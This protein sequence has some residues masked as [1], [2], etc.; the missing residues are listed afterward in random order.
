MLYLI[1][2]LLDKND[3][4]SRKKSATTIVDLK[5][6]VCNLVTA[7]LSGNYNLINI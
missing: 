3:Y 5:K 1:R 2:N 7:K 6:N 4:K